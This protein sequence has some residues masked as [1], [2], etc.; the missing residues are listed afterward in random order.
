MSQHKRA[1]SWHS[2]FKLLQTYI[3]S[4][5][6]VLIYNACIL[7]SP[8]WFF[9]TNKRSAQSYEIMTFFYT[10]HKLFFYKN[11]FHAAHVKGCLL[12]LL[13]IRGGLHRGDDTQHPALCSGYGEQAHK[14]TYSRDSLWNE[15]AAACIK[16]L[17]VCTWISIKW[18]LYTPT[19]FPL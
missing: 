19:V 6:I 14:E 17:S 10:F 2:L 3:L 9:F 1:T 5:D 13:H 8:V 18:T 12:H 16:N 11:I 4:N 15:R 7:H